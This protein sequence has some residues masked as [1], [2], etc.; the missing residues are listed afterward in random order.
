MM[1]RRA[2]GKSCLYS[3]RLEDIDEAVLERLIRKSV[4][5]M[6]AHYQTR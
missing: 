4:N 6:R 2:T 1:M 3:K 5:Y